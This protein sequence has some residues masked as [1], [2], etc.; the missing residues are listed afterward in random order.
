MCL[1]IVKYLLVEGFSIL[2]I[3]FSWFPSLVVSVSIAS[4]SQDL[5]QLIFQY[6]QNGSVKISFIAWHFHQFNPSLSVSL[7]NF[8]S[9][10]LAL[11]PDSC[12]H[13]QG[14]AFYGLPQPFSFC[15]MQLFNSYVRSFC[16][17]YL[18]LFLLPFFFFF[19]LERYPGNICNP[20]SLSSFQHLFPDAFKILPNS[21]AAHSTDPTACNADQCALLLPY[22]STAEILA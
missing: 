2:S 19:H 14:R 16:S 18:F 1:S 6:I 4:F 3:Y 17:F 15:S 21:L 11:N 20:I 8:L 22:F 9:F 5:R 10:F 13:I 7:L 12:F